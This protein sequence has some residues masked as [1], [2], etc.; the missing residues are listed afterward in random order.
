MDLCFVFAFIYGFESTH[1]NYVG[2]MKTNAV[3]V[4]QF[5][6]VE[7]MYAFELSSFFKLDYVTSNSSIHTLA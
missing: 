3:N 4:T 1:S 5:N 7:P 2:C 6:H